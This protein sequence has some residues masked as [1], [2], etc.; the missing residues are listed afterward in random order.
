MQTFGGVLSFDLTKAFDTVSHKIQNVCDKLKFTNLNPYIINWIISFLDNRK[1]RVILDGKI[2][3]YVDIK[4][5]VP[6]GTVLQPFLFSLMVNDIGLV[7]L[8]N[9]IVKYADDVTITVPIR[10]NLDT[11]LAEVKNRESWAANNRMSLNLSK[12]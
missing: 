12:T 7:D 9:G 1:Q 6:Q 3:G 4:R 5:G 11:A 8:N 10:R 2:T